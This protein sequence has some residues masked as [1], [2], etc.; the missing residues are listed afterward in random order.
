MSGHRRSRIAVAV[1]A[2]IASVQFATAAELADTVALDITAQSLD[3][4][5]LRFSEQTGIQV[6]MSTE[7]VEGKTTRGVRGQLPAE[8]ALQQLLEGSGLQFRPIDRR[9][10]TI[11]EKA[12]S[13]GADASIASNNTRVAWVQDGQGGAVQTG[14]ERAS[15]RVPEESSE[16]KSTK[17]EEIVV[18]GSHIRGVAP[19][20]SPLSV[21]TRKE[22]EQSGAG[23]VDD[24]LRKLPQNFA[25][26]GGETLAN[27]GGNTQAS[28][29]QSRGAGVNLRGIGSGSTLVLVNG[30]R[31][32][33]GGSDGSFVDVSTIPLSAIER[34]EVL[35]DGASAIYGADAVA[36]VI[37]FVL[38]K[39]FDGAETSVR[40]GSTTRSGPD[41]I[42]ASQLFGRS[43]TSGNAM[44]IYDRMQREGLRADQRDF[45]ALDRIRPEFQLLPEQRRNS[46]FATLRQDLSPK[47]TLFAEGSYSRREFEQDVATASLQIH[48]TGTASQFG[49]ALGIDYVLP[50]D[51]R[52]DGQGSYF[53]AEEDSLSQYINIPLD[54]SPATTD[55]SVVSFDLRA[56]GPVVQLP[57]GAVRASLGMGVRREQFN[58]RA[59]DISSVGTDL[60]RKVSSLYGEL[61]VPVVGAANELVVAKRLELSVAGRYDDYDDLG[62]SFDPKLG[63]LWAPLEGVKFRGTYATSFRVPPLAQKTE[64]G[65][66]Y[67]AFSAAD[68]A[69]PDGMTVTLMPAGSGN[70]RLR[71][72][73]ARSLT[74]GL[75]IVPAAI[76]E[77][78]FSATWYRL[79]YRDRITLP[80]LVGVFT[81]LYDQADTLTPFIERAPNIDNLRR[82]YSRYPVFQLD[83]P[84]SYAPEDIEA[85]FDGSLQNIARMVASGAEV[86]ISYDKQMRAGSLQMQVSADR[87]AKL[88]Y[89]PG[90]GATRV[91]LLNDVFNPMDL[92]LR[93]NIGF[94]R[95][96]VTSMLIMSH[97]DGYRNSSISPAGRVSSWTTADL[98]FTYQTGA[99]AVKP[100]RDFTMILTVQNV[101]DEDPPFVELAGPLKF[102]YDAANASALGRFV[103]VQIKRSW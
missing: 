12:G 29:N 94:T 65:Q 10:V 74:A 103:A 3:R 52:L 88:D 47:S 100:F 66:I 84:T 17:L 19:E 77:L 42:S 86:R 32:A 101:T 98:S 9:A 92:K 75:D 20:S 35:T 76:P 53:K 59:Q 97:M 93:A 89:D 51:W 18:T 24:F 50:N 85:F 43:W 95:G 37:N 56:D 79:D 11:A 91:R 82:I 46:A 69:A 68:A 34:V 45:I 27:N 81:S 96:S 78:T 61:F 31:I 58:N 15:V 73:T 57:V 39:D 8:Q 64:T 87:L 80:P 102:N 38:R 70:P 60:K 5:L 83:D 44:I 48:S 55:A 71:P 72:E 25:L 28:A 99:D 1:T 33:A 67:Y 22:I 7:I 63:V 26:V 4:A 23:T 40:Y 14:S 49:G 36:G 41:E 21:Y 6:L 62:S 13:V 16:G 2:I 30:R 54:S 90:S